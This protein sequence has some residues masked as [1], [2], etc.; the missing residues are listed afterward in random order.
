MHGALNSSVRWSDEIKQSLLPSRGSLKYSVGMDYGISWNKTVLGKDAIFDYPGY[1][2]NMTD[3]T[4]Y[5]GMGSEY[6]F[7]TWK[8]TSSGD[9][10]TPAIKPTLIITGII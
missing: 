3:L 7:R 8:H 1:V 4:G 6:G 2:A 9:G 5:R 10:N